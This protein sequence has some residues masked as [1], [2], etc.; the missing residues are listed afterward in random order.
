[1]K[2]ITTP[3]LLIIVFSAILWLTNLFTKGMFM[4]GVYNALFAHNL[5]KNVGGFWTPQTADYMH[6]SYWDNPQL[7]AYFLSLW[8]K[9]FGD[10]YWVEKLYSLFCA[11][12]QLVLIASLWKIYFIEEEEKK[13][14]WLPCLFF[15]M[16]PLTSWCYSNNLMENTMSIFTSASIIVFLLFLRTEKNLVLYSLI[17]G[18]LILLALLTKGPVALFPLV[19]PFFF[20]WIERN[21]NYP[22]AFLYML[23]QFLVGAGIFVFVFSME[24]PK[25]FLQHYLEVQ[26]L[27]VLNNQTKTNAS[28]F[29]ILMQLLMAL[30]PLLLLSVVSFFF[31]RRIAFK[32]KSFFKTAIVFIAIGLSASVPIMISAKQN[33]HYLLPSLPVFVVGFAC[34]VL[35]LV[36]WLEKK[37]NEHE[38][39]RILTFVKTGCVIV[40]VGCIFLSIKNIGS[41]SRDEELLF[42]IEKIQALVTSENIIRADWSLYSDW[43]LRANLNRF[44]DKKICMPNEA[45]ETKFYLTKSGEWGDR[46][47]STAHKI[48]SGKKFD[49]FQL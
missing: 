32:Y 24:T 38:T 31:S 8:Y 16:I 2:K 49:L 41:Y 12:A 23:I 39:E 13:Y 36:K 46:L 47:P 25:N 1:M 10:Y 40:I 7:S 5:A 44:Y 37:F 15:L 43:A 14:A 11:I 17:G 27:P 42:D 33:K 6:P 30:S 28:Q 26:L 20:I 4:D 45:S 18:A 3:V 35:P 34:L 22:K 48:Y 9:F 19:V 21:F 29:A